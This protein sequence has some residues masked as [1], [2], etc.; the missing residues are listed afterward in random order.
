M[1]ECLKTN[2]V[3]KGYFG[4]GLQNIITKLTNRQVSN[5]FPEI[6]NIWLERVMNVLRS[7]MIVPDVLLGKNACQTYVCT[8]T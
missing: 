4:V 2:L 8:Y 6:Y 5:E 3:S 7:Y 1:S